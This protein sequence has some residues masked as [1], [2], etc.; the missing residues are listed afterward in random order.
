M[1]VEEVE[2][3]RN[4]EFKLML[5]CLLEGGNKEQSALEE[6]LEN[7]LRND[8]ALERCHSQMGEILEALEVQKASKVNEIQEL[9]LDVEAENLSLALDQNQE[10]S[11]FEEESERY[12][13]DSRTELPPTNSMSVNGAEKK[14]GL[15]ST[16][17]NKNL[18][19]I[20]SNPRE[21]EDAKIREKLQNEGLKSHFKHFST[22]DLCGDMGIDLHDSMRDCKEERQQPFILQFEGTRRQ[23]DIPHMKA[24]ECKMKYLKLGS[25]IN[26]PPP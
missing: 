17:V 12:F 14:I 15:E 2:H 26:V 10:E 6:L 22:L 9:S 20:D 23:N 1:G 16:G 3:G 11:N 13:E 18:V 24:K 25:I 8:L 19:E 7:S 4:G 21:K 5:E